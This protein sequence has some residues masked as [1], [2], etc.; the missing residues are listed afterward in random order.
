MNLLGGREEWQG[1]YRV[2]YDQSGRVL[3]LQYEFD[4]DAGSAMSDA[5]GSLYMGMHWAD[6]AY[7][8]P[9]Y[10]AN[11]ALYK[12]NTPAR[13]SMRAPGVL[14][15]CLATEM[16]MEHVASSLDMPLSFVQE[17][18]F[19]QP[20]QLTITGQPIPSPSSLSNVWNMAKDRS[21]FQQ[22]LAACQQFNAAN[23]F[24]KRGIAM[25]PVKYGIG[26][27]GYNAGCVL[28]V[29][30]TDG[31]VTVKHSGCEVGQGINTKVAQAV[32]M[33]LSIPLSMVAVAWTSTSNVANGGCTGGSS[34]SEV[35]VQAAVNAAAVLITRLDAYR[36]SNG[37]SKTSAMTEEDW[38]KLISSVPT[39]VSLT[40]EGWYSPSSNPNGQE[41]QYFVYAA[42]A[43]EVE[44]DV[45][46]GRLH[47]LS[48]E[49]VYDCGASLNP[50]VDCGQ[51]EGA[52][53]LTLGYFFSERVRYDDR[54]GMLKTPGTWEYKPPLAAD[55]PSS[56]RLTLIA[57]S[58]N[59]TGI[60]GSKAV[61]EPPMIVANA[62]YLALKMAISAS[63]A[64][65]GVT[66]HFDL[67][68]PATIE[69]RQ[70]ACLVHAGRFVIPKC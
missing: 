26:W 45:L 7:Y 44:L 15:S 39:D 59:S 68:V 5:L 21:L 32:A 1:R 65:A 14:Q 54:S 34:T 47:V 63:R 12:T 61:G 29:S 51:I 31:M 67:A 25:A 35:T 52:L 41:W 57:D 22:R 46:T 16:V 27:N 3:G 60:L 64:D 30:S 28:M 53:V 17:A 33:A 36:G 13:T 55:I 24:T 56:L 11:A 70:A 4:V 40:A 48:T 43:V 50:A 6:N 8:F 2:G 23:I 42:C 58:Y 49:M 19:I 18:N 38:T 9:N 66:G 10:T 20:G 62:A 37:K 69:Q